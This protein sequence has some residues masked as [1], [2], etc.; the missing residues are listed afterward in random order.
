[1]SSPKKKNIG[2]VVA[3]VIVILLALA[4]WQMKNTTVIE[5]PQA[6]VESGALAPTPTP[7]EDTTPVIQQD[8]Q[9]IDNVNLD[10]ELESINADLN[11]L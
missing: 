1:M 8:L 5:E 4:W 11:N 10:K 6:D 7:L 9:G 2:I 3:I